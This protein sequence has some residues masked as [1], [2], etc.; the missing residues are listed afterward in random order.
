MSPSRTRRKRRSGSRTWEGDALLLA[1]QR[2]KILTSAAFLIGFLTPLLPVQYAALWGLVPLLALEADS[3]QSSFF[4]VIRFLSRF[5]ARYRSR[6][7]RLLSRRKPHSCALPLVLKCLRTCPALRTS[8]LYSVVLPNI[9]GCAA[10]HCHPGFSRPSPG[11]DRLGKSIGRC[12]IVLSFNRLD[13]TGPS[14]SPLRSCGNMAICSPCSVCH[15]SGSDAHLTN[16]GSY[17]LG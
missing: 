1:S 6:F 8:I 15:C 17:S 2:D 14:P 7:L 3:R 5:V 13:W 4:C 12:R 9:Q 11:P 16:H 10:R